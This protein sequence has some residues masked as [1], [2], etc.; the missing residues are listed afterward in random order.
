MNLRDEDKIT[1]VKVWKEARNTRKTKWEERVAVTKEMDECNDVLVNSF[2]KMLEDKLKDVKATYIDLTI[3]EGLTIINIRSNMTSSNSMGG[4]FIETCYFKN[5]LTSTEE[6]VDNFVKSIE[7]QVEKTSKEYPGVIRYNE[8]TKQIIK[9]QL[10][11][12]TKYFK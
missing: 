2:R 9:V 7:E 3:K 6:T 12:K 11:T 8:G 4:A 1:S 10:G 5:V